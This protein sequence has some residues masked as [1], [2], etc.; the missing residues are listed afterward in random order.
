MIKNKI[1]YLLKSTLFY[2]DHI[3]GYVRNLYFWKY[4][5]KLPLEDFNCVLDA[6]CGS[7]KYAK[8]IAK[9]YSHLKIDACDIK[10]HDSWNTHSKN[11]SF[12]QLDLVE[13]K[14]ENYYDFC[15]SIEVLEHIP[16]NRKVLENIYKSLKTGG[17]FYLHTPSKNDK[18]IFPKRFFKEFDDWAEE[19]HIG[20][21]YDL[22]ELKEIINSVGF[23]II[24]TRETF[25]FWGN[26]AWE[27]DRITDGYIFLKIILMPL[28][29]LFAYF[30]V[31]FSKKGGGILILAKK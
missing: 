5:Q 9:K 31:M 14:K 26:F 7:G 24:K 20:E 23:E 11:I 18:R 27:I 28:L 22:E 6:G 8:K 15:Y 17:Y 1:K 21:I 4:V 30:D 16:N 25:G 13:L 10:K 12:Q 29:K 2:P 19:E 3:G